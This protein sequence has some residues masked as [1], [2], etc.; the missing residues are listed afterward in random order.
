MST[1]S[2]VS[3]SLLDELHQLRQRVGE[4]E[5]E[6]NTL[7][8]GVHHPAQLPTDHYQLLYEHTP[9]MSFALTPEGTVLSV[10]RFGAEQLGYMPEQLNGQSV[11]LVFDPADHQTVREQLILCSQNPYRIFQWEIQKVQ[12]SGGRIWVRE[13]ARSVRD[14]QGNLIVLVMCE[15]ITKHK[16]AEEALQESEVRFRQIAETIEEVVWSADPAIGKMLYI[17]PAY[18]RVW[19]RTCASLYEH[20]KSF[21]DA[22]HPDDRERILTDLAVQRDGLPFA[23]EYRVVRPDGVIRWVWDRGFPVRDRETGHLT[24]YVGAALDITDRKRAEEALRYSE[25]RFRATF[26]N[27]AIGMGLVDPSGLIIEA[28]RAFSDITGYSEQELKGLTFLDITHPDDRA[29]NLALQQ[30]AVEGKRESFLVEKRYIRKDGGIVWVK[31]SVGTI[32][33]AE[34]HVTHTVGLIEDISERKR[35]EEALLVSEERLRLALFAAKQGIYDHDLTTGIAQVNAEYAT[36]LGYDPATFAE[37]NARWRERLHPDDSDK[38]CGTYEAYIRGE[39]PYYKVEFRQ[40]TNAGDWK[41]ILSIG[42]IVSRDEE[43]RPLRMLGTHTDIT[44]RKQAE[45]D[46]RLVRER[47]QYLMA[48]SPSVIYSCRISEDYGA[49]YVSDNILD[50]MGYGPHEF[51]D[52][53]EFWASHIHPDDRIRV[54][55]AIPRI[56]EEGSHADEYRFLH[57]DGTYRWMHDRLKLVRDPSG[58]PIEIIGSWIDI[59]DRKQAEAALRLTQFS[60]EHAVDA[61]FWIDAEAR[62]LDINEAACSTLGY[63]RDELLTMTVPDIDPNFPA[64]SWPAH[65]AEL[66]ARGSFS[67]ET[68]H[69]KK[70]GTII[71][72]DTTVNFLVHEGK[73]YNCAFMRDITERKRAEAQLHL[74]QF[75]VN[76]AGDLIFWISQDAG[77]HYVNKAA[78]WRLGYS[79]EELCRMKVADIDP[80]YQLNNWPGH[81][82]ELR[83]NGRLRFETRHRTKSGEVYPVEVVANFVMVDGNEYNFAFARD[84]SERKAAEEALRRSER[85]VRQAFEERERLSQ[86]LH[87]NLLQS[88][89]AVGMGLDVTKQRIKRTS[90]V[91]AKRLE[92]SVAQLNAVIRDVRSFI[93]RLYA[94]RIKTKNVIESLRS[95]AGSFVSTRAGEIALALNDHAALQLSPEQ[96]THVLAIAKEALSNSVRHTK[97]NNRS[98][99]LTLYRGQVR[100]EV[101]DDGDGFRLRESGKLGM[102]IRNMRSRAAKINARFSIRTS[103]GNGTRLSLTLP[104]CI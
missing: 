4:L 31:V 73:E 1:P 43:G 34:G 54:L 79:Q 91:N 8:S 33:D 49:T 30:N 86:D 85:E 36:M 15:D 67:F 102:G 87:D 62:I 58:Q 88:L 71:Q 16:Q 23:H 56:F 69:R 93:P 97:A 53:P 17:S 99:S 82:E 42:S 90:P 22:I 96:S 59:T 7:K 41:W 77:L 63:T 24:H 83:V 89:Y 65:W 3:P 61:I 76:Q 100:L 84:I 5:L 78:A 95:L 74:T 27:A 10:N 46:L 72:T 28:N 94:P 25:E 19:G 98:L 13:T 64:D 60:I 66:K 14:G 6:R 38:V 103:R 40:R 35:A 81:W 9:A 12:Q 11:L 51:I 68:A 101:A 2:E 50:Q 70:D 47:L 21:I 80:D 29:H 32:H 104:P 52:D 75:A 48:S 57:K 55:T 39:T 44:E 45:Q 26:Q 18:E 20:P 92:S 37:T